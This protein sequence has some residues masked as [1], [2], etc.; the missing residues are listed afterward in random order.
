MYQAL[1]QCHLSDPQC[2]VEDWAAL[3]ERLDGHQGQY[4]LHTALA[5][6]RAEQVSWDEVDGDLVKSLL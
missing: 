6:L 3:K 1:A 5:L 2:L 4:H